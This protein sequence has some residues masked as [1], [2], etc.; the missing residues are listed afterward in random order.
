MKNSLITGIN[1]LELYSSF[2]CR[3]PCH[4]TILSS[5]IGTTVQDIRVDGKVVLI[6]NVEYVVLIN[7]N[8]IRRAQTFKQEGPE[9]D[10]LNLFPIV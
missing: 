8:I 6:Y 10:F 4:S 2:L 9:N 3:K 1:T 7:F 5:E